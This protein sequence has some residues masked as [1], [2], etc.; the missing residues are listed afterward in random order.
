MPAVKL[1]VF[2]LDGVLIEEPGSWMTIHRALGTEKQAEKN[3]QQ[4]FDKKITFA[5]WAQADVKLWEGANVHRIKGVLDKMPL[6]EGAEDTLRILKGEYKVGILSGGLSIV[7]EDLRE[8][9]G[10]DY[11]VGNELLFDGGRVCGVK[12]VVDF[13]GKGIMLESICRSL[14]VQLDECAAV[15]DHVNDIPMFEKA[16]YS[17]AFNPKDVRLAD[18][19]DEVVYSRD[20]R[21]ILGFF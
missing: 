1:I 2:D 4:F 10:L 7:A 18:Y 5:E 17:V 13:Y 6:M 16:G 3:A 12:P 9:F 21:S 20:L 8:R 14:K 19:A 11:A 15:G